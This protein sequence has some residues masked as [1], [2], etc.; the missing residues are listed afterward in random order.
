MAICIVALR[1]LPLPFSPY[2]SRGWADGADPSENLNNYTQ[3]SKK[4]KSTTV[5]TVSSN[6]RAV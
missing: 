6:V 4:K 1:A 3:R 2:S 5:S